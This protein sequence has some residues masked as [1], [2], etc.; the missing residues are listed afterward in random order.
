M[1]TKFNDIPKIIILNDNSFLS[2]QLTKLNITYINKN[3]IIDALT[4][5]IN[6][7]DQNEIIILDDKT[8][9]QLW[10]YHINLSWNDIKN[11][12]PTDWDLLV[13]NCD[14]GVNVKLHRNIFKFNKTKLNYTL[15][16]RNSAINYLHNNDTTNFNIFGLP[17][18]VENFNSHTID[19]KY[20]K[21]F[22]TTE[23]QPFI[24]HDE[25]MGAQW[26]WKNLVIIL[27]KAFPEFEI[28]PDFN[29]EYYPDLIIKG[30]F[31]EAFKQ[32]EDPFTKFNKI[33]YII[34]SGESTNWKLLY[35]TTP[36]KY[37][38]LF[39]FSTYIDPTND[40]FLYLPFLTYANYTLPNI[41]LN[42]SSKRPYDCCL[43]SSHIVPHRENLF[44]AIKKLDKTN[45]CHLYGRGPDRIPITGDWKTVHEAY[46]KYKFVLAIEN[47]N[48]KGYITEKIMNAFMAGA[49]PVFWGGGGYAETIFNPNAYIDLSKFKSFDECAAF[50]MNICKD[51]QKLKQIQN[52][53]IF[54]NNKIPD[55]VD[56]NSNLYLDY[57]NRLKQAYYD[58]FN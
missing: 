27:Q 51:K 45:S 6:D 53:P 48:Q 32:N 9:L 21:L 38:P 4:Y 29:Y 10:I 26:G 1:V 24:V 41:K 50:I 56:I 5:F 15:W 39:I 14:P 42:T 19:N 18:L 55:I 40:K 36:E 12:L 47:T 16:N 11:M 49:I 20:L 54:K 33:P 35:K 7:T 17:L 31:S 52:E 13:L 43:C 8:D 25:G 37:D 58:F 2:S 23:K 3:N 34:W 57:A 22:W 30:V 46:T 28:Y 44:K